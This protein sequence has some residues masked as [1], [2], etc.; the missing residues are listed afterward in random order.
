MGEELSATFVQAPGTLPQNLGCLWCETSNR[1]SL[2]GGIYSTDTLTAPGGGMTRRDPA[3]PRAELGVSWPTAASLGTLLRG[4]PVTTPTLEPERKSNLFKATEPAATRA[5]FKACWCKEVPAAPLRRATQELPWQ[6]RGS[7]V[8]F[9]GCR[10]HPWWGSYDP[11][12]LRGTAPQFFL[13]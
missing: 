8:T 11:H 2:P 6:S 10:F 13:I 3:G 1:A 7:G 4:G 9:Q 5:G 12:M